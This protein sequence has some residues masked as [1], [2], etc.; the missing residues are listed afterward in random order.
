MGFPGEEGSVALR[1]ERFC[2]CSSA[3]KRSSGEGCARERALPAARAKKGRRVRKERVC[4][5]RRES[6]MDA[7]K[8]RASERQLTK[9][10]AEEEGEHNGGEPGGGTFQRADDS[11]LATRRIVKARRPPVGGAGA[12]GGSAGKPPAGAGA[13]PS[14][15][16]P[17]GSKPAGGLFAGFSLIKSAQPAPGQAN[18]RSPAPAA[19][20]ESGIGDSDGAGLVAGREDEERR[21]REE[22]EAALDPRGTPVPPPP[23]PEEEEGPPRAAEADVTEA[24]E[25]DDDDVTS[26]PRRPAGADGEEVGDDKASKKA[27]T[28]ADKAAPKEEVAVQAGK[29]GAVEEKGKA[30][31]EAATEQVKEKE[32]GKEEKEKPKQA[33][34]FARLSS[35]TNAFSSPFGPPFSAS[36]SS[37]PFSF[38]VSASTFGTNNSTPSVSPLVGATAGQPSA[39]PSLSSV[40]G[41]TNGARVQLFGAGLGGEGASGAPAFGASTVGTSPP[42]AVALPAV[43]VVTGEEEERALFAGDA[44]LFEFVEGGKWKE[45]GKG[46]VRLNVAPDRDER[47]ARLVMRAKG[48]LRLLL[49]ANLFPE[50]KIE[51]MEGGRGLSFAC[52]NSVEDQDGTPAAASK[53]MSTLA[54]RFRDPALVHELKELLDSHKVHKATAASGAAPDDGEKSEGEREGEAKGEEAAADIEAG[55]G[56]DGVKGEAAA[57]DK[58]GAGEGEGTEGAVE[59]PP[60]AT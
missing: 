58:E 32:A 42:A 19:V 45:R 55:G 17:P 5:G 1:R 7:G 46:E 34:G 18:P 24:P 57:A 23:D 37:S 36:A 20:G 48:N 35:A 28:G 49:N 11:V 54:L 3:L 26:V 22:E 51:R 10:T 27:R 13:G 29:D 30:E 16:P 56:A 47:P 50:M 59:D 12:P 15:A 53:P 14:F 21:R 25:S 8:K 60:E 38:G 31:A 52:V 6:V 41:Q 40:F 43:D 44:V 4:A 9:D 2:K 39:F 33:E